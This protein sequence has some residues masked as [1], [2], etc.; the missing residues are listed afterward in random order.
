MPKMSGLELVGNI[1]RV[2]PRIKV[3]YVSGFLGL[4][5]LKQQLEGE[6]LRYGYCALSKPFKISSMLELVREY[7]KEEQNE[8]RRVNVFA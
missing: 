6:I 4:Q 2:N 8:R 1:R 5:R 7:M 3:V